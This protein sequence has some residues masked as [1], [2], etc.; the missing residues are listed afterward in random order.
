V[1]DSIELEARRARLRE[2][3]LH[4][5]SLAVRG[6]PEPSVPAAPPDAA[7]D[8]RP[9]PDAGIAEPTA[10]AAPAKD[11]DWQV[12][13]I[14]VDDSRLVVLRGG[15]SPLE[16]AASLSAESVGPDRTFPISATLDG[17]GRIGV[18]G[19]LALSPPQAQLEIE[20]DGVALPEVVPERLVP[21]SLSLESGVLAGRISLGTESGDRVAAHGSLAL[22]DARVFASAAPDAFSLAVSDVEAT[23]ES[24]RIPLAG[25]APEIEWSRIVIERPELSIRRNDDGLV[26]PGSTGVAEADETGD[27]GRERAVAGGEVGSDAESLSGSGAPSPSREPP[28]TLAIA[29]LEIRN[30][31]VHFEDRT[32]SPYYR[33]DLEIEEAVLDGIRWPETMVEDLRVAITGIGDGTTVITGTV[34]EQGAELALD[35]ERVRL[36]PL[37]P[38]ITSRS[39]Y[40]VDR[41]TVSIDAQADVSGDAYQADLDLRL[42]DLAIGSGADSFRRSFGVPLE[43]GL[44]LLRDLRGDIALSVPVEGDAEG[45]SVGI[46]RALAR[47]L[48]RA[49]LGALT[50]PLKILGSV[51]RR[52]GE[53]DS[54]EPAAIPFPAG[55]AALDSAAAE[56]VEELATL[57]ARRPSLRIALV[58]VLVPADRPEGSGVSQWL[59]GLLDGEEEI[60][61][62]ALA[63]RRSQV[64]ASRLTERF[65][66]EPGRIEPRSPERGEEG[67]APRVEVELVGGAG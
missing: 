26:L 42:H 34:D 13:A 24:A 2:I 33:Q 63:E 65:G 58:P 7:A 12:A 31:L 46:V 8:D 44:S 52:G 37:N 53:I 10:G 11:W 20:L 55:V 18:D 67:G 19:E 29:T 6:V 17:P 61:P 47:S 62:P 22:H 45:A 56:R 25:S 59:S 5:A 15:R 28:A 40:A 23:L 66:I 30:G 32:V 4:G 50:S 27:T 1:A 54:W 49:V 38:Y 35:A 9:P 57:L 64:V 3:R 60:S 51:V 39:A 43:L 14:D 36:P 48:H 21:R 41:G 16:F